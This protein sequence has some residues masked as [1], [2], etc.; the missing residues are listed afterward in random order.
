MRIDDSPSSSFFAPWPD[1][2]RHSAIILLAAGLALAVLVGFGELP[3]VRAVAAFLSIVAAAL[4][5]WQLHNAV[6]SRE[7]IHGINPVETAA[8]SAIIAG[9]PDAAVRPERAGRALPLQ[10]AP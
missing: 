10:E 7:D 9:M 6:T 1:R 4:V 3:L 2:L 8:V 5:P